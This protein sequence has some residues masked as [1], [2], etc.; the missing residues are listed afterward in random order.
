MKHRQNPLERRR[1]V[2]IAARMAQPRRDTRIAAVA[3]A[4]VVT[5]YAVLISWLLM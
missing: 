2:A 1:S 3:A 5:L 4:A